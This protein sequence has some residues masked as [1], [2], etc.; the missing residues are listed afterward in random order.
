MGWPARETRLVGRIA[1]ER[2]REEAV[3]TEVVRIKE[4]PL[5]KEDIH[6][7]S[8][9]GEVSM[10]REKFDRLMQY[11]R[12]T[13]EQAQGAENARDTARARQRRAEAGGVA[14][15]YASIVDE[16]NRSVVA[17]LD[18][19]PIQELSRRTGITYATC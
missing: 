4:S 14:A 13:L 2:S 8:A 19:N 11:L 10:K 9:T 15:A 18:L 5:K 3:K 7:D 16:A 12:D 6:Y 17:L 1:G